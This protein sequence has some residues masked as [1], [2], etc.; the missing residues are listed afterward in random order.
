MRKPGPLEA[1]ATALGFRTV[2]ATVGA[3]VTLTVIAA[4]GASAASLSKFANCPVDNPHVEG[5]QCAFARSQFGTSHWEKPVPSPYFSAGKVTVPLRKPLVLQGGTEGLQ[6]PL[7]PPENGTLA[8]SKTPE[9]IPGGLKAVLNP[10]ELSGA[11]LAAY[12]EAVAAKQTKVFATIELAPEASSSVFL[13][14]SNLLGGQ[15]PFL[16]MLLKVKFSNPLLGEECYAGSDSEPI[17]VVLTDGTTSPP[18][19]AEPMTGQL[20]E[21]RSTRTILEV[22]E[23]SIVGNSFAAPGVHGCGREAAW[24]EEIDANVNKKAGLPSPAGMNSSRID[25]ELDVASSNTVKEELGLP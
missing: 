14:S 4:A 5:A 18:P 6:S 15:G 8:L 16:T 13:N 1:V 9:P 24:Q 17:E 11:A 3:V 19:P 7:F 2:V 20:G 25:G 21:I 23:D 22:K 12:K 10:A